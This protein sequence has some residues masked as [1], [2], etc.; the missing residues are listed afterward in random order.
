MSLFFACT[1][2][3]AASATILVTAPSFVLACRIVVLLPTVD[4]PMLKLLNELFLVPA[5]EPDIS[6]YVLKKTPT[7]S[8]IA[9]VAFVDG[10]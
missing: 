2:C 7:S 5:T 6:S 9:F 1:M 4:F 8:S 10:M 3:E